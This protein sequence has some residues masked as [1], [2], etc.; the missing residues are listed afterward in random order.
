M[1]KGTETVHVIRKAKVDKIKPTSG[2][3]Q[4]F[5][6]EDVH[7][8]PAASQEAEGGWVQIDGYTL[9]A[10]G[11]VDIHQDDRVEARGETYSVIGKPGVYTKRGRPAATFATLRRAS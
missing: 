3:P 2:P 4:E 5:D 7:L 1:R 9:I 11:E 10:K 6:I 8:I